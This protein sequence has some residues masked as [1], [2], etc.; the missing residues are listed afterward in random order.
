MSSCASWPSFMRSNR[1]DT[2]IL[3]VPV[4]SV[5]CSTVDPRD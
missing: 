1:V 5:A 4:R 2:G 3:G